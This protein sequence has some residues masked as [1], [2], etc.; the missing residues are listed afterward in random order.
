M[1]FCELHEYGTHS[2]K[3]E[4]I[5]T[6]KTREAF[7]SNLKEERRD[8]EKI[9]AAFGYGTVIEPN[10]HMI[11]RHGNVSEENYNFFFR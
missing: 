8:D 3:E 11:T 9:G 6:V 4:T 10:P 7:L 5:V 1:R 2:E